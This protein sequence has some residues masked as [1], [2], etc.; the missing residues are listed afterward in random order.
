MTKKTT[1]TMQPK[2][3]RASRVPGDTLLALLAPANDTDGYRW[4][5][6]TLVQPVSHGNYGFTYCVIR[7]TAEL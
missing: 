6:G 2:T 1:F 4:P 5:A 7:G 3:R